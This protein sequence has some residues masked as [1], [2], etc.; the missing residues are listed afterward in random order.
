MSRKIKGFRNLDV[1]TTTNER[2][3]DRPTRANWARHVSASSVLVSGM[4][5]LLLML[6][7]VMVV[8]MTMML[9]KVTAASWMREMTLGDDVSSIQ[10]VSVS[11]NSSS[12][13]AGGSSWARGIS[14]I[15]ST[16]RTFCVIQ[17]SLAQM[18]LIRSLTRRRRRT[19]RCSWVFSTNSHCHQRHHRATTT[20]NWCIRFLFIIRFRS[21]W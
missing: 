1:E 17:R 16:D 8:M 9:C 4:L 3:Y 5:L 12:S 14:K 15:Q 10:S 6:M 20:L 11:I 21:N 13:G 18:H 2:T 19:R 7:M